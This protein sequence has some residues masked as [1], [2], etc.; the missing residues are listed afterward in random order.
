[1]LH[2]IFGDRLYIEIQRHNTSDENQI[3]EGLIALAYEKNI[4]LVATND[5]YFPS[6]DF[7]LAHDALLCIADGRYISE[8]DRRKVTPEHY[9]KSAE[10]MIELFAD[11]P[12][13]IL[14]TT[15]IAQRCSYYLKV[16]KPIL[17]PFVTES[18]LPEPEEFC[19]SG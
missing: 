7:H 11:L 1:M 9:L 12:E 17:P 8:E 18:G 13:A 14:N 15:A 6:R 16:V 5:C 10:E 2:R 19:D 4:P 3:E